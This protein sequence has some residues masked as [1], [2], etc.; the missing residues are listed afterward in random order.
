VTRASVSS[1]MPFSEFS[2]GRSVQ[3]AG[4]PVRPGDP[5]AATALVAAVTN[6]IGAEYFTTLGIPLLGGRDF[7]AAEERDGSGEKVAI[8]DET[9]AT[10]LFGGE[11]P[12][13]QLVQFALAPGQDAPEVLRVVGVAGGVRQDLFDAGPR[14]SLYTPIGQ[15]LRTNIYF[16]VATAAPGVETEAALLPTIRQA[17]RSVDANAPIVSL[18]TRPMFRD[19]N[20]MVWIVSA[21]AEITGV[22]AVAALIVALV[23]VYGV[24]AY[25]VAR[26]TR[27]IGIRVAL[28]ARP[29][30]VMGLVFRDG[31]TIALAGLAVGLVLSAAAGQSV[32]G[33]IFQG[34]AFDLPVVV[35]ATLGLLATTALAT[36][37]PARRALRIPPTT[38]LRAE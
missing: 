23:G 7:S 2:D 19:R 3:R 10:H 21:G 12:I 13:G 20:L 31:L 22:L 33:M 14:P 27:E 36:W 34:R 35:M 18:E 32:R 5:N 6:A 9:L 29:S 37:I 16:H 30:Q 15:A 24:K 8:I 28:G 26:R 25:F 17:L 4:A 1:L 11:N 38:A